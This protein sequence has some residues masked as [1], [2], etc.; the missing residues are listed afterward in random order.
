MVA[1]DAAG[2][3]F[4]NG[5]VIQG[6]NYAVRSGLEAAETAL[7]ATKSKDASAS[8]LSEY[9]RRLERTGVLPDFRDFESMD[10]VKWN[11]RF[12]TAYPKFARELFH[13]MMSETGEPKQHVRRLVRRAQ[14][15]AGLSSFTL[16]RDGIDLVRDL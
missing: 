16:L 14:T 4:S 7:A 11:P 3:V 6:M 13:A 15:A 8:R 12:Y 10:R 9:D 2:F 1:G 5:I